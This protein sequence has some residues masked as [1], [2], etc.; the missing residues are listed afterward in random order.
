MV[1]SPQD[2]RYRVLTL[3]ENQTLGAISQGCHVP[4]ETKLLRRHLALPVRLC[5]LRK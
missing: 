5:L 3:R 1:Y 2:Y 4:Q